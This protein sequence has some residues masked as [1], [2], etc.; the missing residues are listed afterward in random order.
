M[1]QLPQELVE[2]ICRYLP[3]A[4]LKNVL[5]LTSKFQYASERYSGT[6]SEFTIDKNNFKTFLEL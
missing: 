1:D 2:K 6:F 4:D 3:K 5:T